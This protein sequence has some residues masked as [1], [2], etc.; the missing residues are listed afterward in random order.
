MR[1]LQ[2]RATS[3]SPSSLRPAA[4]QQRRIRSP[5]RQSPRPFRRQLHAHQPRVMKRT[6][7]Q[8]FHSCVCAHRAL[9]AA[10][11]GTLRSLAPR[12]AR[13]EYCPAHSRRLQLATLNTL[14]RRQMAS[15]S[16]KPRPG[17][18]RQHRLHA[19][20]DGLKRVDVIYRASTTTSAT[21]SSP[22]RL[23]PRLSR[24]FN[25]Y[26]AGNVTVTNA[27]EPASPTTSIYAYVR[28]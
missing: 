14:P 6:F 7:P 20:H 1:G 26:R 17:H 2:V 22:R 5:R 4:P 16:L 18:P 27:S 19:H 9:S 3:T 10:S 13:A 23:H 8:L 28:K 11:S 15:I 21:R 24:L 25:A 12:A